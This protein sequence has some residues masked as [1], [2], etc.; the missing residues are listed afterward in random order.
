MPIIKFISFLIL[1]ASPLCAD[2]KK[3]P[4]NKNELLFCVTGDSRGDEKGKLEI[5][6]SFSYS[7]KNQTE[8][9]KTN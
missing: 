4:S 5:I 9:Q 1:L 6:D 3:T 2:N 8:K 7:L